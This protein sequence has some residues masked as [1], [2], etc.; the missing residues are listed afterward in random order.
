[1]TWINHNTVATDLND[2]AT[3]AHLLESGFSIRHIETWH[4]AGR[5]DST[6]IWDAIAGTDDLPY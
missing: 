5:D 4:R 6:I 1:M 3:N 2:H